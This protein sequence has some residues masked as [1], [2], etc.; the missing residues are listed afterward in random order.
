MKEDAVLAYPLSFALDV[1]YPVQYYV[2][3]SEYGNMSSYFVGHETLCFL[4]AST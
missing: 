4:I 3:R 2:G 1:K